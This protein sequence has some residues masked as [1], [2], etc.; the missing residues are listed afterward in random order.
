MWSQIEPK[1]LDHLG[2]LIVTRVARLD[3]TQDERTGRLLDA[4]RLEQGT[5]ERR[6][7]DTH[8]RADVQARL[9]VGPDGEVEGTLVVPKRKS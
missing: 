8:F 5:E 3:L 2:D 4:F 9:L 1:L 7:L 6:P